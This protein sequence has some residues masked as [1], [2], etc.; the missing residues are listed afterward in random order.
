MWWW[1][2]TKETKNKKNLKATLEIR[3]LFRLKKENEAIKGRIF[4]DVKNLFE[5]EED[6]YKPVRVGNF[7]SNNYIEYENNGDRNKT[8]SIKEYLD[9]IKPYLK[10]IINNIRK[11]GTWKI[12][13]EIAINFSSCKDT[14]EEHVIIKSGNI[15][16]IIYDKADEVMKERFE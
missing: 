13:L 7:H 14:D 11:P 5:Q 4:R 2:E 3:N 1:K 9:E 16:I 6:Y 15:E 12:Q 8:P 10:G